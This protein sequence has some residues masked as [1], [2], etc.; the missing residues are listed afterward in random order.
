MPLYKGTEFEYRRAKING[1]VKT[2]AKWCED[3]GADRLT[4]YKRMRRGMTFEKAILKPLKKGPN[5][6]RTA[7]VTVN[8]E[9]HTPDEWIEKI[10]I[11]RMGAYQRQNRGMTLEEAITTPRKMDTADAVTATIDGVTHTIREWCIINGIRL[12]NAC[13]HYKETGDAVYSVLPHREKMSY[14]RKH[15]VTI[16][17]ATPDAQ[18]MEDTLAI[19]PTP[20]VVEM[21]THCP[22]YDCIYTITRCLEIKRRRE[23]G[24]IL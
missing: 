22:H 20:E 8:G 23:N 13:R 4:I 15:R 2:W 14:R 3:M 21:C 5:W 18:D 24:E 6:W 17:K 12:S 7:Q 19:H 10:G 11:S 1:V 9:T 16:E